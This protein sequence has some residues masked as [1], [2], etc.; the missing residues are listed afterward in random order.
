L[1]ESLASY[2]CHCECACESFVCPSLPPYDLHTQSACVDQFRD[3]CDHH[4]SY[5]LD[6]CSYCQSFD[7]D[8]SSCPYNDVFDEAYARL[9]AMIETMNERHEYFVSEMREFSLLKETDPSLPTPRLELS[10]YDG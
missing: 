4:S 1:F 5:P 7:H 6:V 3:V 10:P 2:Q 9:N 8:V